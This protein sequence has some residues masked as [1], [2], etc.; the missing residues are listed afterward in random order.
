MPMPLANRRSSRWWTRSRTRRRAGVDD[1]LA[2]SVPLLTMAAVAVAGWQMAR[3]ARIAATTSG[4][5]DFLA[6]KQ[7]AAR[8]FLDAVVPEAAG[9]AAAATMGA[10]ALYSVSDEA[11]SLR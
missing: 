6:L 1:R 8:Y 5:S 7:A 4:D 10:S 3:Q 9:L 2:G 11:L